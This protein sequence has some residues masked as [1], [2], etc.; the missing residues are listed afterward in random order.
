MNYMEVREQLF[1]VVQKGVAA[2]L[3]RGSAGNFS[4]RTPNGYVAITPAGIKYDQLKPEEIAVVDLDGAHIDGPCKAS[5]E[6]PMHTIILRNMPE[7]GAVCHTHSPFAMTFAVVG[8]EI[9]MVT[10]ELLV[11]G[12][13]IP[14]AAWA[15]PGSA[16]G[17]EVTVDILRARPGLKIVLL[18]N[19]GLVSI[20]EDINHAFE[21][22]YDAEIAAQVYY[23]ALQVGQPIVLTKAQV[24]EVFDIYR[25]N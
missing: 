6:T 8:Q 12:A 13:P 17:G 20:G 21:Y 11:V 18:R 24:Q 5:S 19:H 23:Q 3:I 1:H 10:T 25:K 15:S 9:P 16:A 7:V 22:A 2:G 14:V 4:M